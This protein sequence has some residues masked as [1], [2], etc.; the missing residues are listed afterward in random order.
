VALTLTSV[1]RVELER[2]V[3]SLKVRAEDARRARVI[4]MLA[5]GASYSMI[6]AV[7][8]CYRDYINRWRRRFL[9]K[10]LERLRPQYRG[11]PPT[12]LTPAM[13]TRILERIRQPPPDGS[14]PDQSPHGGA[15]RFHDRISPS[16]VN[17][18]SAP[19]NSSAKSVACRGCR[20]FMASPLLAKH[21]ARLGWRKPWYH[22]SFGPLTPAGAVPSRD[23]LPIRNPE[24]PTAQPH[25]GVT[26]ELRLD[27]LGDDE[28]QHRYLAGFLGWSGMLQL[29]YMRAGL[30]I[31]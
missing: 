22:A 24:Q 5:D 28:A 20:V 7:V 30:P 3:R 17:T 27:P 25:Y 2:R 4:L 9:A 21:I 12:V 15:P 10:R 23:G 31:R 6:E 11:Q 29:F 19:R 14:T 16:G 8:P 26:L 1:E 13:E 18:T